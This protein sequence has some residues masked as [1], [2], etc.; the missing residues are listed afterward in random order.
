MFRGVGRRPI[1]NPMD[2][3][4]EM[5]TIAGRLADFTGDLRLHAIPAP[6]V[7]K[8]KLLLLDMIGAALASSSFD[9]GHRAV[10]GLL[11]LGAGPSIVIG[12]RER[13][14]LRDAVLAN[15]ILVHGL[16]YDDTSIYGRVHPSS[17]CGTTV[18]G[19]GAH[20]E[21]SGAEL[22]I[23]YVAALECAV[24][25]GAVVKGG[26]QQ[27]GFHP[28]GVVGTFGATLAAGRLLG[29]STQ[30]LGMAQ[31]I[32]LSMAAGS[33]EFATDGAWTKRMH[34]GWAGASGI[35]AAALAKSG[36]TG[37]RLAYEGR[38]GLYNLYLADLAAQCDLNL[39][40]EGLGSV[41]QI[42]TIALKPLP[43]CYFNVP[44]I[45]AAIRLA[46]E[47]DLRAGDIA[48]VRALLP[49]AAV[50]LVCE[51][52]QAKR[53]PADGY[54]AQ[55]SVQF[56]TA[57]A[58]VRRR[59]TLDDLD[60]AALRDPEILSLADRVDYAVDDK[61]TFPEFYSGAVV[62]TTRDGRVLQAREDINRGAPE[63]PLSET[64]IIAKFTTSAGRVLTPAHAA[65]I[66][67]TVLGIERLDDATMLTRQLGLA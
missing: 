32:A 56:T 29:L 24:R 60:D 41:W 34:P 38:R 44:T 6:I 30:E 31:G 5:T 8:A 46:T 16:D 47:H 42:E 50:N 17:S 2:P 4:A 48:N 9:F 59:F 3:P 67:E 58:L 22:L 13:L 36:F 26:F 61:T 7:S 27:R 10:Q 54:A 43:A 63:R 23:A 33:Q 51:P 65:R 1:R 57:A 20:G 39:A 66:V 28:T 40:T 52:I 64:E 53:R 25:L 62:V 35:T 19:V 15:G 21:V 55:F 12:F 11:A 18:L 45:D 37:P 49:Q 14:A